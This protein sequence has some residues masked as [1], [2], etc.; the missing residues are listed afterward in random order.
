MSTPYKGP[1][2]VDDPSLHWNRIKDDP[3]AFLEAVRGFSLQPWEFAVSHANYLLRFFRPP[4]MGGIYLLCSSCELVH[5]QTDSWRGSAIAI[6]S[7]SDRRGI[8]YSVS[9]GEKL[10]I[11]CRALSWAESP[12]WV[13]LLRPED[14]WKSVEGRK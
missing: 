1:L 14:L 6:A 3:T 12:A 2:V 10:R 5:F 13:R 9:D 7:Q 11:V 8:A 4:A